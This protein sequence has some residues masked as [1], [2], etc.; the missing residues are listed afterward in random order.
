MHLPLT[1]TCPHI[2][3][4]EELDLLETS[5]SEIPSREGAE[6]DHRMEIDISVHLS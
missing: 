5:R 6:P 1:L 4:K 2:Y 3:N